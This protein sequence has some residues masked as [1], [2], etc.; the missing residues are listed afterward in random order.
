M[1][2]KKLKRPKAVSYTL[3]PL[4]SDLGQPMYERLYGLIDA[5]HEDLSR[6][7]VRVALAWCTS[8]KAD[9]D[10][11]TILGKCKKASDL[12]RELAPFDFVIL[13]NRD[14]WLNPHVTDEQR[15]AL[16]DHELMHA[17]VAY[18][19]N[20]DVKSDERGRICFR[21]RK[22]DLEEFSDIVARHGVW[23]RDIEAFARALHRAEAVSSTWVGYTALHGTL[24]G[25]GLDIAPTVIATWSEAERRDAMR[26]ASLQAEAGTIPGTTIVPPECISIALGVPVAVRA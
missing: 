24:L 10:G 17:A 25:I 22:H 11:R 21:V 1:K 23:K 18:D 16:V 13:L 4:E 19:E 20:G 26:Y 5:H 2:H 6:V 9:V 14:F 15:Q 12:D 8:W 3:I 7:N